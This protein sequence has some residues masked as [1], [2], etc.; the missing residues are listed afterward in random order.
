M[1]LPYTH[2]PQYPAKEVV[3]ACEALSYKHLGRGAWVQQSLV[4]GSEESLVGVEPWLEQLAEELAED[5]PAINAGFIQAMSVQQVHPDTLL[6][7]RLWNQ[8]QEVI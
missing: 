1:P 5:P 4:S 6:Q 2:L 7:I 3:V 8:E